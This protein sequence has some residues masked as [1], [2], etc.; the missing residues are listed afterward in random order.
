MYK[1]YKQF[2]PKVCA[3]LKELFNMDTGERVSSPRHPHDCGKMRERE[4][5]AKSQQYTHPR[6]LKLV[7]SANI[8][9]VWQ[10]QSGKGAAKATRS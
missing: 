3:L 4:R 1:H 2:P 7:S 10:W 8:P 9:L 6:Q 5:E